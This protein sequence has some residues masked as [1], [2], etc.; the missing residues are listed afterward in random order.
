MYIVL[1]PKGQI[2]FIIDVKQGCQ[3]RLNPEPMPSVHEFHRLLG[4]YWDKIVTNNLTF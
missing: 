2:C 1:R 3:N 4:E